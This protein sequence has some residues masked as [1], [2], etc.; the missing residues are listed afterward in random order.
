MALFRRSTGSALALR[1]AQYLFGEQ[2]AEVR[3]SYGAGVET[4]TKADPVAEPHRH[5]DPPVERAQAGDQGFLDEA[6]EFLFQVRHERGDGL[7]HDVVG[8]HGGG[9]PVRRVRQQAAHSRQPFAPQ[10]QAVDADRETVDEHG[11]FI[12]L[13][14]PVA[15][16]H[17]AGP[18]NNDQARVVR[19]RPRE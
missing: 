13:K 7:L 8:D 18:L 15:D 2:L 19:V 4:S 14:T 11:Y 6:I 5:A 1:I 3:D 16:L 9:G 12:A 17:A 10:V